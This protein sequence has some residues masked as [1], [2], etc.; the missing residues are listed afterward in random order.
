MKP[1]L[2]TTSEQPSIF[3][4]ASL[5]VKVR[6][7]A[8]ESKLPPLLTIYC[9]PHQIQPAVVRTTLKRQWTESGEDNHFSQSSSQVEKSQKILE[10]TP[11]EPVIPPTPNS[12]EIDSDN[13]EDNYFLC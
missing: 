2:K 10:R 4:L 5:G 1:P 11:T 7:F 8:F 6:D 13:Y 12:P 3:M 9:H